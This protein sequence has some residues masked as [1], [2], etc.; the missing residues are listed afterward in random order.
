MRGDP[1]GGEALGE[2]LAGDLLSRGAAALL[3]AVRS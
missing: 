3:G 1:D 2:R